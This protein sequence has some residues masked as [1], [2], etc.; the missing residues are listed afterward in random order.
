MA[1]IVLWS[2]RAAQAVREFS[3]SDKRRLKAF[4]A[5]LG[6]GLARALGDARIRVWEDEPGM[7]PFRIISFV[8]W[9]IVYLVEG[10]TLVVAD[11]IP[12]GSRPV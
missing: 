10:N 2:Q 3:P 8:S 9:D 5:W 1:L 11:V 6:A 7:E 4:V 12:L